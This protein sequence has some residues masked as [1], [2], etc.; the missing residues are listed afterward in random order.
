MQ[1]CIKDQRRHFAGPLL[2]RVQMDKRWGKGNWMPMPRF[3]HVQPN[4]KQ[5]PIDDGS[6][7][8][9]NAATAFDETIE[10]CT[11]LQPATH[12]KAFV[13]EAKQILTASHS[14]AMCSCG[15]RVLQKATSINTS[16]GG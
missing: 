10:C 9:H 1:E 11:A 12:L 8:F 13:R 15:A 4:G 16:V 2:T 6:R 14:P 5:R 7:Y 3:E